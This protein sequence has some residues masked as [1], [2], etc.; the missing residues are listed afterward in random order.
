MAAT[1]SRPDNTITWHHCRPRRGW[2]LREKLQQ[3]QS[4]EMEG[5]SR[6]SA[7][8]N[9]TLGSYPNRLI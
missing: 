1:L 9:F 7:A 2:T 6:P 4:P 3:E 5:Q 8:P